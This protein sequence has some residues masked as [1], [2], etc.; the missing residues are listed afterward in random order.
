[1]SRFRGRADQ[2]GIVSLVRA[3]LEHL[4]HAGF[5]F[6]HVRVTPT[7]FNWH[8]H[9]EF[10]LMIVVGGIG[11]RYVGDR[12]DTF[13]PGDIT[14]IGPNVSHTWACD[15]PDSAGIEA[16]VV[17]FTREYLGDAF[18]ARSDAAH[19]KLLLQQSLRGL[20]FAPNADVASLVKQLEGASGLDCLLLLANALDRLAD[21][22]PMQLCSAGYSRLPRE[23]A[24]RRIDDVC[25]FLQTNCTRPVS[26]SEAADLAHMTPD[27]F[28]RFFRRA[29]GKSFTD[30]LTELRVSKACALLSD[31]DLAIGYIATEAGFNN[32]ANFNR[33][34]KRVKTVTPREYRKHF[35]RER[36]RG[37]AKR[38]SSSEAAVSAHA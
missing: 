8:Y 26:I 38:A 20:G 10:E 35:A 29:L 14:L 6:M 4:E 7:H 31:T 30:Y 15:A 17:H 27:S 5:G 24:R 1:L 36:D 32:L 13:S 28:S 19:L 21:C 12:V 34:F 37:Y 3:V 33:R 11:T 2:Q 9:P 25:E 23:L 16:L 22:E 18:L